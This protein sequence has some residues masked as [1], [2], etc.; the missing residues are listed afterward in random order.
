M[1]ENIA[2]ILNFAN[3]FGAHGIYWVNVNFN[4]ILWGH[5]QKKIEWLLS[6]TWKKFC[7]CVSS[8][9]SLKRVPLGRIRRHIDGLMK[10][11]SQNVHQGF[12][13]NL[14][15]S[16]KKNILLLYKK[17]SLTLF[18]FQIYSKYKIVCPVVKAPATLLRICLVRETCFYKYLPINI[19]FFFCSAGRKERGIGGR[20]SVAGTKEPKK[21]QKKRWV[22]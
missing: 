20:L 22:Y 2:Q 15:P 9:S 4:Q 12:V 3:K 18:C 7:F 19:S 13:I 11:F 14:R 21:A 6:W 17:K 16:S 10:C 5:F 8:D 1:K